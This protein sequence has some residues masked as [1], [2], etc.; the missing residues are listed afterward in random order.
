MISEHVFMNMRTVFTANP[1]AGCWTSPGS[2]PSTPAESRSTRAAGRRPRSYLYY[3]NL[4]TTE[5]PCGNESAGEGE[6]KNVPA[7]GGLV[8]AEAALLKHLAHQHG[9]EAIAA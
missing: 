9:A 1:A 2:C 4:A 6:C 5:A 7:R 8:V 3:L